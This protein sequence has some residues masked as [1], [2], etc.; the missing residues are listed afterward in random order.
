MRKLT[1]KAN[2]VRSVLVTKDG[3]VHG[4]LVNQ[5]KET[6]LL[7]TSRG[8]SCPFVSFPLAVPV[9]HLNRFCN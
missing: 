6:R 4:K 7:R 1:G 9:L 5:V 3:Q 2:L 8:H